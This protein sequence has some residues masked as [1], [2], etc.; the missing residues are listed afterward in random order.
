MA[1]LF[2][3]PLVDDLRPHRAGLKFA[4]DDANLSA[5]ARRDLCVVSDYNNGLYP[6]D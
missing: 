2:E 3:G 6:G 5:S 4:V 1:R